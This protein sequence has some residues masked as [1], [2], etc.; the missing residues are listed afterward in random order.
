M[1]GVKLVGV[2]AGIEV[3]VAGIVAVD[4]VVILPLRRRAPRACK[5]PDIGI[6]FQCLG[7]ERAL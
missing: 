5:D 6:D 3:G 4:A 7:R 2:G 1:R